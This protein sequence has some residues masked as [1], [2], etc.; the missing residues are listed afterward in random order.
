MRV[1]AVAMTVVL[2]GGLVLAAADQSGGAE[3]I[4]SL[5]E[6]K[7]EVRLLRQAVE[8]STQTNAHVQAMSIYL[9]AQQNRLNQ[10][11]ARADELRDELSGVTLQLRSM[12]A[13][14]STI[15]RAVV[16]GT[17]EDRIKATAT[18]PNV[19][20]EL[21]QLTAQQTDL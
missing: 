20:A 16:S 9:S 5:S 21:A 11:T 13:Y 3:A 8:K 12:L 4:G 7:N 10:E 6:L 17:E 19:K 18:L 14:A 2:V 15:E 1:V